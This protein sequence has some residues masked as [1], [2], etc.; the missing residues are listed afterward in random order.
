[1]S[2]G[3]VGGGVF[4]ALG[5]YNP[6]LS[7]L[8]EWSAVRSFR[9]PV[10]FWLL[11]A[12]GASLLSAAAFEAALLRGDPGRRRALGGA[13]GALAT[14]LGVTWIVFT[15]AGDFG[16][17]ALRAVVPAKLSDEFVAHEQL[18]WAGWML[19]SLAL[20][21]AYI[22]AFVGFRRRL[23]WSA[24]TVLAIHAAW[25]LWVLHPAFPTDEVGPYLKPSP[26]LAAVPA[27]SLTAHG[28]FTGLF[29]HSTL[30]QGEFP[31]PRALWIERRAFEELYPFAGALW[32]RRFELNV[33][34]EGLDSFLTRYARAAIEQSTDAERLQLLA[35]WGVDR[36]ILNRE[37]EPAAR[38]A[39][40]LVERRPV[41]GQEVLVY[42]LRAATPQV[43]FAGTVLTAPS[44]TQGLLMLRSPDFDNRRMVVLAGTQDS[45]VAGGAGAV[46]VVAWGPEHLG[47]TVDASS[48]G[49]L[50]WQR[51]H[52]PIYRATI[53][54][55]GAAVEPANVHRIGVRVPAGRHTVRVW[56]DHRPTRWGIAAALIGWLGLVVLWRG[57]R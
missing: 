32:G 46:E 19:L 24:A 21:G 49:V 52:L 45:I 16:F 1:W 39:A 53:D 3:L 14:I 11:V 55:A 41:S 7:W 50:V 23:V 9:Y 44:V 30:T 33:S 20:L 48:P 26:L 37:L 10:K 5:R 38:P 13:L 43:Y 31:D 29:Q 47:A 6:L 4:L 12:V 36:L 2:W 17:Q 40:E 34:P 28:P 15:L 42:R 57:G 18:R 22:A 8:W 56:A 35:A 54:D 51:A 25:Q 27:T